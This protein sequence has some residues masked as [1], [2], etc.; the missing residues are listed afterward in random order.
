MKA[1][2]ILL[3]GI[4]LPAFALA[5][6][7]EEII[8]KVDKNRVYTTQKFSSRMIISKGKSQ[9]IKTMEG[10]G[11]KEGQKSFMWFTNPEDRGVK[12]LK[13]G[14]EL[15]IYFPDADDIM[16]ISG[17]MLKQGMMGSDI[18]YEDMLET[19]E[20]R[21]KYSSK[22]LKEDKVDGKDCYVIELNAV[23]PDA[24]YEKQIIFVDKQNFVPL[25]MEMFAK[26][27]RMIKVFT[28]SE[29][30]NI[31]GRNIPKKTEIRDV[32]RKN[33]KTN[34]EFININFDV[35]LSDDFFNKR[36]LK[37]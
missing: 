32:R 8:A 19:E 16:K 2:I 12:Y 30:I 1:F 3:T 36:N 25:K 11:K 27:G 22:L 5:E 17:H 23:V 4:L 29:I 9:L 7:A 10:Y 18:S 34:I 26:G 21:K 24:S 31:G 15:W 37:R 35:P 28:Q 33:S 14:K 13:S 6:T 20:A